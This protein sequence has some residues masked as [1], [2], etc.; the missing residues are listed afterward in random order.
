MSEI[1][2]SDWY[3]ALRR[4]FREIRKPAPASDKAWARRVDL[5][6]RAALQAGNRARDAGLWAQAADHYALHLR[7]KPEAHAIHIQHG[8]VLMENGEL[9]LSEA[10]YRQSLRIVESV[11]AYVQL[12]SNLS[13]Q[14]RPQLALQSLAHAQRLEPRSTEVSLAFATWGGG[15]RQSGRDLGL[16]TAGAAPCPDAGERA[17]WKISDYARF[18]EHHPTPRAPAKSATRINVWIDAYQ[19]GP[20]RL[21]ETIRGL[22]DQDHTNWQATILGV[23]DLIDHPVGSFVAADH[24]LS[25]STFEDVSHSEQAP[26]VCLSAGVLLQPSAL[27]WLVFTLERTKADAVF[28]DHEHGF[29]DWRDGSRWIN[30]ILLSEADPIDL[31]TTA[32]P[33]Q[34]VMVASFVSEGL[35]RENFIEI[36]R[37]SLQDAAVKGG[38]A[39]VPLILGA[40]M[41]LPGAVES[42][43]RKAH[44]LHSVAAAGTVSN[45]EAVPD[46]S[47]RITVVI[48]TR[49]ETTML[50]DCVSSLLRTATHPEALSFVILD[51]RSDEPEMEQFLVA[52]ADKGNEVLSIDE[53]FNWSRFNNIGAKGRNDILLFANNDLQMLSQGWDE[54][55]RTHLDRPGVGVVGARLVYED[56]TIQ[57]AGIAFGAGQSG[58]THEGLGAGYGA[59]GPL[60]RW[61]RARGAA[62]VT[63]AF[64]AVSAEVFHEAGGFNETLAVAYNDIDFCLRVRALGKM[65]IYAGE[66]EAVHFESRSRGRNNTPV[67]VAWD[68]AERADLFRIWRSELVRD[69]SRNPHWR[70]TDANPFLGIG[71]PTMDEILNHIDHSARPKSWTAYVE[72]QA[73]CEKA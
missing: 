11:N 48:P 58:L 49:N 25:F 69:P 43:D 8:N 45:V 6:A 40:V 42:N 64:M 17:I 14:G 31:E 52:V 26:V 72:S 30:P 19:A 15:N 71:Q 66:I 70:G 51:N 39:H 59:T 63:G 61:S 36:R 46:K 29:A 47:R 22:Q 68:L 4:Y 65:V 20:I 53:P 35:A 56:R 44:T 2:L 13:R 41:E 10:A 9:Y 54:C 1:E 3:G 24:R 32:Y 16:E 33:P 50:A 37:R 73:V 57:H 34:I 5:T 38:A 21:R 60:H 18:R 27:S 55:V 28:S 67:K 23:P 62:A 7:L 12:A